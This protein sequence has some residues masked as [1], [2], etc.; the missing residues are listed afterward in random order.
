ME[1]AFILRKGVE[2]GPNSLVEDYCIIGA[3]PRG[4]RLG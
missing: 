1:E 2:L 4:I 3:P